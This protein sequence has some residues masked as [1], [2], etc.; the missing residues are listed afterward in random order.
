M[1]ALKGLGR[2]LQ[3]IGAFLG[4]IILIGIIALIVAVP[5]WYF[6][7]N[8]TGGYTVFVV[9]LIAAGV[10]AALIGRLVRLAR[11]PGALR[12]YLNGTLLPILKKTADFH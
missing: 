7:S 5:L 12:V 9:A 6:S 2:S 8:F 1:Q 10:L 3:R 11:E 4:L